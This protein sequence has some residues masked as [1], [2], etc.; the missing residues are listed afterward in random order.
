MEKDDLILYAPA[1]TAT[2]ADRKGVIEENDIWN[3]Y[4]TE[5]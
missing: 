2:P 1:R 4:S 5:L 3:N